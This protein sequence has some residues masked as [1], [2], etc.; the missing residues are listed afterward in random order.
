MT[1]HYNAQSTLPTQRGFIGSEYV[2][3]SSDDTFVTRHP[4]NDQV[5][6]EVEKASRTEVDKAI[7]AAK[8][9]FES[10]SQTP[11]A[12]RGKILRRATEILRERNTEIAE[13]ETLDTGKPI[14]ETSVVDVVTG[15]DVIDY[16]AARF[17]L[18]Q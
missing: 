17:R 12:E 9:A 5:I 3:N 2:S 18:D 11:A 15:A 8:T 13:L 6:C 10:W 7:A 14:S 16:F 4:G 1:N